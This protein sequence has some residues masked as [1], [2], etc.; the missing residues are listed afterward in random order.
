M[1]YSVLCSCVFTWS[2]AINETKNEVFVSLFYRRRITTVTV[3]GLHATVYTS[4][5]CDNQTYYFETCDAI[6]TTRLARNGGKAWWHGDGS[7]GQPTD[8]TPVLMRAA[9]LLT[10]ALHANPFPAWAITTHR[11]AVLMYLNPDEVSHSVLICE[12]SVTCPYVDPYA[13]RCRKTFIAICCRLLHVLSLYSGPVAGRG[14]CT[15][16][17]RQAG[18]MTGE[19]TAFDGDSAG[20]RR[21]RDGWRRV[22]LYS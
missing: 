14:T 8:S 16:G 22:C 10:R 1:Y 18:K 15:S 17:R 4:V 5:W 11:L 9:R 20:Q 3:C 2:L 13:W 21:G 12:V 7:G 6:T 19:L